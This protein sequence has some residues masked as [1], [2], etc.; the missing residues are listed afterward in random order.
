[1]LD[2][3]P[4]AG[5]WWELTDSYFEPRFIHQLL[6]LDFPQAE[7]VTIACARISDQHTNR[8]TKQ[9]S[10]RIRDDVQQPNSVAN[11]C[12]PADST[13]MCTS[14]SRTRDGLGSSARLLGTSGPGW[15]GPTS[16]RKR[17]DG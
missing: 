14:S 17:T 9:V 3:V 15:A 1:V 4:F 5:S 8:A 11:Y 7:G 6:Q 2:L 13:G 16:R 10:L 12:A